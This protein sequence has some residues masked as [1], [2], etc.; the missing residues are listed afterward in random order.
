MAV[1][2]SCDINDTA[3][4][5]LFIQFI[6]SAGSEELL[7][8]LPLE[9]QTRDENIANAIIEWVEKHHIPL[10]KI[11]SVLI[12]W[13]KNHDRREKR[14]C[15]YF[16]GGGGLIMRYLFTSTSFIKKRFLHRYF[17]KKFGML[18]VIKIVNT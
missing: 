6:S 4:V 17:Q 2:E 5:T 9:G 16:E 11:I 10:D 1:E 8:L 15:F 12:D 14:F 7:G 13:A 3:Q 18:W